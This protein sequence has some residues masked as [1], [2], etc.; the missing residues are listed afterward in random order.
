[1]N[2]S[3]GYDSG[4]VTVIIAQPSWFEFMGEPSSNY[5]GAVASVY[6]AGQAFGA[7]A[8]AVFADRHGRIPFLL[9]LSVVAAGGIAIQA[10]AK[11][12]GMFIAGRAISGF[13]AGGTYF[14]TTLYLCELGPHRKRG[15]FAGCCG[16]SIGF[17]IMAAR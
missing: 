15:M 3:Y 8:Q 7:L 13:A 4:M 5:V 6:S 17:G 16:L 11:D 12:K 2:P 10:A 1:M 9:L 14:T